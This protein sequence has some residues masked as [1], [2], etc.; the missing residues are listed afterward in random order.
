MDS[1]AFVIHIDGEPD[2]ALNKVTAALKAEG[3]G[4]LTQ[5]DV[6]QTMKEKL[7]E[8]FRPYWIL[9]ACNPPLAHRALTTD[10]TVGLMLPCNVTLEAD[11]EG[12]SIV[13][14]ANPET[15]I[16]FGEWSNNP[17]LREVAKLARERLEKAAAV[18]DQ[19]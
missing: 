2:K 3:F 10:S 9:G 18:L 14:I 19:G 13:R 5:I 1:I 15:M 8:D 7:G 17:E 6:R 11:P 4:V 12:G 16:L